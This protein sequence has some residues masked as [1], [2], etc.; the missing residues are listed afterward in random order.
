MFVLPRLP[1]ALDALVPHMSRETL[2]THYNKHHAAYVEKTNALVKEARIA[3]T[4]LEDVVLEAKRSNNTKLFNQSAQAWN[5]GFFWNCLSPRPA[6]APSSP[7]ADAIAKAFGGYDEFRKAAIAMGETHFGSGWLW[8]VTQ[9]DGAVSLKALHDAD[10]PLAHGET[11]V[12]T[13]DLWEHAYY[14]D[15][16]NAR[17]AFLETFFGHLLD[18][19]FAD[20]QYRAATG[21]GQSWHYPPPQRAAA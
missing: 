20:D 15:H 14:L 18:W 4:S 11:A 2:D 9:A 16:K 3:E 8:L 7:L 17:K 21:G 19:S 10:N 13:C 12:F 5:H 6:A 1:Y